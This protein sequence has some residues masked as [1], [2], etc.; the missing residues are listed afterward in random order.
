MKAFVT[1]LLMTFAMNTS[2]IFD[3]KKDAD[4]RSWR[5]V[6][7]T[8]MGGRSSASFQLN[9]EGYGLFE[10]RV[11][12]ENNGGFAS[13]RHRFNKE[14]VDQFSKL[15]LRIKGDGKRYQV[16]IKDDRRRYFSYISYIETT[17]EWQDI[18]LPLDEFY[19]Y[20]RG[21][22]VNSPNFNHDQMEE[23]A[24]L[25]GNKKAESFSLLIDQ[26]SLK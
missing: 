5:I 18:E 26:I 12:L 19:A 24:L 8:V 2:L 7:D 13:L 16:R 10:G 21:Y 3:F 25:I 17:G 23:I 6:N 22:R 4:V 15:V 1:L 9:E 11:S 14:N 20:F